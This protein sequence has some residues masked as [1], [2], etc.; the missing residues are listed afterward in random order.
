MLAGPDLLHPAAGATCSS[1]Q[2]VTLA[3]RCSGPR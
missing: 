2:S 3:I 1:S